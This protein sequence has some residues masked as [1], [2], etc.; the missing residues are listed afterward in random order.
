MATKVCPR[1]HTTVNSTD[2][3]CFFCGY[4]FQDGTGPPP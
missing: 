2:V 3:T 1:C 4:R